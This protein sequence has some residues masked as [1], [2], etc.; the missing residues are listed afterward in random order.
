MSLLIFFQNARIQLVKAILGI[1]FLGSVHEVEQ[2]AGGDNQ[3]QFLGS[4]NDLE[5]L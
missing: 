3:L 2:V 1:H 4:T 5:A